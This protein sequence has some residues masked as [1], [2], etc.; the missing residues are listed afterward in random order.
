MAFGLFAHVAGSSAGGPGFT[1]SS[2][3]TTGANLIVVLVSDYLPSSTTLSDSRSNTWTPLTAKNG[4]SQSRLQLYYCYAPT[5]DAAHTF[6]VSNSGGSYPAIS[7]LA[8]SGAAN[9]PFDVENGGS[10]GSASSLQ[11]GSVTPSVDNEIVITGLGGVT[12]GTMSINSGFTISDQFAY[13]GSAFGSSLAY[14]VQ[15]TATAENP[16]WSWNGG[17]NEATAVI[18]TFKSSGAPP[19]SSGLFLTAPMNGLGV[20]GPFFRS[21]LG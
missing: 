7:V 11:P 13:N 10:T 3:D 18:A 21:P 19:P 16:T 17:A 2:L 9:S 12:Q 14:L 1:T 20:G 4:S 5:T 6:T 8:L 15:T